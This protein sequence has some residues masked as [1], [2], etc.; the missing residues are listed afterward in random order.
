MI[1]QNVV[2][3]NFEIPK[4]RNT[5]LIACY[6]GKLGQQT[7]YSARAL[8]NKSKIISKHWH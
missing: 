8:V 6:V 7:F 3:R 4:I 2:P 1:T 5:I